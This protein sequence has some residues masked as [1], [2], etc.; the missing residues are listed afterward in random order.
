MS[1]IQNAN[2]DLGDSIIAALQLGDM[3][4]LTA[5]INWVQ[6]LLMNYHYRMPDDVLD[7]YIQLYHEA[8]EAHLDASGEIIK[9]WFAQVRQS[10][11]ITNKMR[12]ASQN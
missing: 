9:N 2:N 6:G 7:F 12:L 3:N 4:L 1:Y 5:N 11:S 10:N 8:T